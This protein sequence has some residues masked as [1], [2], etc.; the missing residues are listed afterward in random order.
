MEKMRGKK[1]TFGKLESRQRG[2]KNIA[3]LRKLNPM[4]AKGKVE[5]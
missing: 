1:N 2:I 3:G 5:N 4:Q